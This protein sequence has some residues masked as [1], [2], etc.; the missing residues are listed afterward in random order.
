MPCWSKISA[1]YGGESAAS[2]TTRWGGPVAPTGTPMSFALTMAQYS[3]GT[4]FQ[5]QPMKILRLG[6][7]CEWREAAVLQAKQR[8]TF[9]SF[10]GEEFKSYWVN[11][12]SYNGQ[13][14]RHSGEWGVSCLVGIE[15]DSGC[16]KTN[17]EPDH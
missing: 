15:D 13:V 2:L 9:R 17:M 1:D 11:T 6:A 12:F 3:D 5:G 16:T 7:D 8:V 14:F 4:P 10:V